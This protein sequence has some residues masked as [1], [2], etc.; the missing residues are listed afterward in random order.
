L[1][2][3]GA[4]FSPLLLPGPYFSPR[5]VPEEPPPVSKEDYETHAAFQASF[6]V[7]SL[8]GEGNGGDSG[9]DEAGGSYVRYYLG[10]DGLIAG[11]RAY[12][13]EFIHRDRENDDIP[14]FPLEK[15]IEFLEN[16][17]HTDTG[18]FR[19]GDMVPVLIA[20]GLCVPGIFRRR[21]KGRK[22]EGPLIYTYKRI[23]A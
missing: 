14:P 11:T 22:G 16:Y 2:S 18:K 19:W 21:R 12:D 23:A 8:G 13:R 1:A 17:N 15:L 4:F 20:L 9:T 5:A 3:L 10:E 6:S 7:N